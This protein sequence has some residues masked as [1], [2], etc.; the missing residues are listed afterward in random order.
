MGLL[1]QLRPRTLQAR[2]AL[3][4]VVALVAVIVAVVLVS[5]TVVQAR[6]REGVEGQLRQQAQAIAIAVERGG[7]DEAAATARD[8]QRFIGDTRMVVEVSGEVVHWNLPVAALEASATATYGPVEVLLERP[9][10]A[11]GP[12]GDWAFIVIIAA[13]LLA[14][15]ALVWTLARAITGGLRE[16]V[17]RLSDTAEAVTAG[18]LTVRAPVTGDE[19]GRLATAFNRMTARLEAQDAR[20][21]EFLADVAHELRTPVTAIEGFSTALADGTAR[22]PE[23]RAEAAE[24]IRGEAA[25]LR[26]LVRDLQL[27]TWLDLEPRMAPRTIDLMDAG[28]AA[29][30]RLAADARARGVSLHPPEGDLA[31]VADPEH[32]DTILANLITNAIRATPAGGFVHLAPVTAPGQAGI[33]V[34]DTGVGIQAQH[35]PFIFDRLY[36]VQSARERDRGGGSG[37]GLSIVRRLATLMGGRVTV[38]S[39]P[40]EG[41]TFTVWL[42][43]AGVAAEPRAGVGSGPVE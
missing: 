36:R 22:T 42:P 11:T 35:L 2:I 20:Q 43:A 31:A 18:D 9:D 41:S 28:R 14:T 29:V 7:L 26:E 5:V 34:S 17:R 15:A 23:D 32:V 3:G 38:Q 10:V 30:A 8:A 16:S 21:R 4:I 1:A 40:G 39:T 6:A 13:G 33:S 37:L 27:V 25:R 12:F 24:T 19:L